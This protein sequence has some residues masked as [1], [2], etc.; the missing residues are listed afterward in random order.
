M[1]VVDA[2]NMLFRQIMNETVAEI[3]YDIRA[4]LVC[5]A[6][7]PQ[8]E[9]FG[10]DDE[11]RY[12]NETDKSLAGP[13]TPE[14]LLIDRAGPDSGDEG[15]GGEESVTPESERI[16]IET[17]QLEARAIAR[18]IRE[19]TGETG[20]PLM[21]YDKSQKAMRPV[22][23][24]DMVILLRSASVWAPL[25]MEELRQEGI[26]SFGEQSKG[27]FQ[28]I[29]VEIMLSLLHVIDNPRQDIPLASVLRSP[30][31]GLTEEELAQIRLCAPGAFYDALTEAVRGYAP[32]AAEFTGIGMGRWQ[33]GLELLPGMA[34]AAAGAADLQLS[35]RAGAPSHG[36]SDSESQISEALFSKLT[37]FIERLQSWRQDARHGSLS[38]LIWRIYSETGYLDWVGGLPGG[39]QRRG[40]LTALY[41]RAVQYEQDT[42]SRGLFR[43]LTFISRL[44]DNGGDLG[45]AGGLESQGNAVRLMTI[46]KSKGLEFPVVF[47]AGL[48]KNFN[49]QDLNAPFLMH[50]EL[51]F[52]PRFF[53]EQLRVAYPT[54][55][56]LAIRRRAQ[57][58][59]LAEEMRVL[60]VALT[61]PK[62]KMILVGTVK[63]LSHKVSVWSQ[64][65][66]SPDLLLPDYMLARGRCYLDWIGPAVIR[67]PSAALLREAAGAAQAEHSNLFPVGTGWQIRLETAES[68]AGNSLSMMAELE[69]DHDQGRSGKESALRKLEP[70]PDIGWNGEGSV[71][72]MRQDLYRRLSW[73]YPYLTVSGISAKTSVTEMKKLL[74]MQDSPSLD[75]MEE[76]ALHGS[77]KVEGDIP[78]TFTLN[79]RRPKFME[80]NQLTPAE[81][82]TVYHTIM[83]HLPITADV[84]LA[85]IERTIAFLTEKEMITREQAAAVAPPE[86]LGL[87]HSEAGRRLTEAEQVWREMPFSYALPATEAYRG[88]SFLDLSAGRL[89]MPDEGVA[90]LDGECVLIQGVVDCL[91]RLN[92]QLVLLDYKTDRVLE[93]RGGIEALKEQYRFQLELYARALEDILGEPIHEKWLYF[94]DGGHSV[95]L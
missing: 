63:N 18:R 95:L 10:D 24:G 42:S 35:G 58:E 25:I 31:V 15:E 59:L 61:R 56:N 88:L 21:V 48:S 1:E 81:R 73:T 85:S 79:L 46:H 92:G 53:D 27:Y 50:K 62:E 52:G 32:P 28:A 9:G 40:N 17:A 2:V 71:Q 51:G 20:K 93:H 67:H 30:L 41:D 23:Y 54:L 80:S 60:Y 26:P 94:F 64:A 13:F 65:D 44:R 90:P 39:S 8:P 83:Q 34:E 45:A 38:D 14:L 78:S 22:V 49:Q 29:E 87:F 55:P 72:E 11:R 16:E 76:N 82:G 3:A 12:A 86:I 75:M 70:V 5:G 89:K 19:M 68:L 36:T 84:D 43:F 6:T 57:L 69:A 66:S 4:E 37:R 91:F 47:I 74:A 77:H 7:Y 33:A